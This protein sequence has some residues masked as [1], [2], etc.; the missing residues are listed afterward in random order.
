M[1]VGPHA[2]GTMRK[3]LSSATKRLVFL[4]LAACGT[5]HTAT[6]PSCAGRTTTVPNLDRLRALLE[7]HA[8]TRFDAMAQQRGCPAD[9]TVGEYI[10][11]LIQ[12]GGSGDQPGE[13][14]KIEGGC[15]MEYN[16]TTRI[17]PPRSADYWPCSIEAYTSDPAGE[18]PWHYE[19][20]LRVRKAD[21]T[22]DLTTFAC[23]GTP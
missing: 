20:R 13:T 9:Q 18:S 1:M 10:A 12:N 16:R 19:L 8:A 2:N 7:P 4:M 14:H 5:P 15:Y 21:G 17:D 11:M 3:A 6:P 22:P 23:P